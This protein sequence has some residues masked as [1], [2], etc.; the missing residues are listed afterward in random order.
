MNEDELRRSLHAIVADNA[1]EP[2]LGDLQRRSRRVVPHDVH[3]WPTRRRVMVVVAA[4]TLGLGGTALAAEHFGLWQEA[5]GLPGAFNPGE[6]LE[7]SGLREEAPSTIE[8]TLTEMGYEVQWAYFPRG[9]NHQ[10]DR[11]PPDDGTAVV[12][13]ITL[14]EGSKA[15][16]VIAERYDEGDILHE[17]IRAGRQDRPC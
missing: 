13:D 4:A 14:D 3:P 17:R 11:R 1:S 10:T 6:P 8:S 7:C 5:T 12:I 9:R 16:M 2:N 15:A